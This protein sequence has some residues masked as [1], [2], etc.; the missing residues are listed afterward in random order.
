V[1][2]QAYFGPTNEHGQIDVGQALSLTRDAQ[3]QAGDGYH[4]Y[5]GALPCQD[6]GRF[7]YSVRVVPQHADLPSP[8]IP[9]LI[10]WG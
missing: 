8:F 2:V 1:D 10:T 3:A 6:S 7:G 9:G 4:L 5:R